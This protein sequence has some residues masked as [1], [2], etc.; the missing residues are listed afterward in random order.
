V[1]RV[2]GVV[3]EVFFSGLTPGVV[4]LNQIN[5]LV[6]PN[7]TGSVLVSVEMSGA[8]SNAV[9]IRVVP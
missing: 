4:G 5:F 8:T 6:P 9:Q 2:G 3:A 7:V 1:V